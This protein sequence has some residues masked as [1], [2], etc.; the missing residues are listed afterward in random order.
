MQR[1]QKTQRGYGKGVCILIF[2]S[3]M[4]KINVKYRFKNDILCCGDNLLV[5]RQFP[6]EC[7]DL[8]YIDPPFFSGKNYDLVFEDEWALQAFSDTFIPTL[9]EKKEGITKMDKYLMWM[10]LRMR[11]MYRILKPSGTFYLHC[12][13]H[14]SH[15]LKILCDTIFGN[16]DKEKYRQNR[17]L[18]RKT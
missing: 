6:D 7:V 17:I 10:G 2:F 9:E 1:V 5:L 4:N 16:G 8:I 12:D 13:H 3:K 18:Q 15:N 11:E 14:A